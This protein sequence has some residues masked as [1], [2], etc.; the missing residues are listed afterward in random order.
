M[1]CEQF[2]NVGWELGHSGREGSTARSAELEAAREHAKHC[3]RCAALHKSWQEVDATLGTLRAATQGAQTP[4]R[5]EMRL[6]QEF[7]ARHRDR[8]LRSTAIVVGW[9]L[10]TA[11]LLVV[12]VSWWN[13]RLT[14]RPIIPS[15]AV[16]KQSDRSRE[17]A[18]S[19]KPD[20]SEEPVLMAESDA[21][22]FTWLPDTLPQESEDAA[23]VRVRLQRRALGALGLP[24]NEERAGDWLQ[25]DLL[26]GEDGQPRAVRLPSE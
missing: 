18:V 7:R 3:A 12:A 6:R 15:V 25:V 24:V 11:A 14:Q 19:E 9:A 23:I 10:A 5:V 17:T 21:G 8:K 1:N 13:W 2:E 20:I 4:P 16:N 22:D 26:V